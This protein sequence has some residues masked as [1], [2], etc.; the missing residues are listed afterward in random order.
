MANGPNLA[1]TAAWPQQ[2][3]I[4][5]SSRICIVFHKIHIR[6]IR[7]THHWKAKRQ[8]YNSYLYHF[9]KF[10]GYHGA[11]GHASCNLDYFRMDHTMWACLSILAITLDRK[12]R[13]GWFLIRWKDNSHGYNFHSF[14]LAKISQEG[15]LNVG[16]SGWYN[17]S[18][19]LKAK[20]GISHVLE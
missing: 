16:T 9:V 7:T 6:K 18:A 14:H 19:S 12:I 13:M 3:L 11:S 20:F 4:L 15:G 10:G 2:E 5:T 8:S 1:H 17:W